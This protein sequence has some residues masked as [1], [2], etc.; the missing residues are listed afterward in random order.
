MRKNDPKRSQRGE[1]PT[2]YETQLF[3]A[4]TDPTPAYLWTMIGMR[5]GVQALSVVFDELGGSKVYVPTREWFFKELADSRRDERIVELLARGMKPTALAE[6][7]Q[8]S[9]GRIC[10]IAKAFSRSPR[11]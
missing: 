7:F 4:L 1:A 10:Q 5:I 11:R 2:E 9:P 3:A 6:K 8:L